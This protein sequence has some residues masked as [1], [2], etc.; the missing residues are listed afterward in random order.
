MN[1]S[2]TKHFPLCF[3]F[4]TCILRH[5]SFWLTL[6]KQLR[7]S[8]SWKYSASLSLPFSFDTG[9]FT[10]NW[11]HGGKFRAFIQIFTFFILSCHSP[12]QQF[13]V[14]FCLPLRTLVLYTLYI[15]LRWGIEY[16]KSIF[17]RIRETKKQLSFKTSET[18]RKM[19]GSGNPFTAVKN[20]LS[21]LWLDERFSR[22]KSVVRDLSMART[23]LRTNFYTMDFSWVCL[24]MYTMKRKELQ[25]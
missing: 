8:T 2:C 13:Y 9:A 1:K 21:Q 17:L 14:S 23:H 11:S 7:R 3:L 15:V 20:R 10:L 24:S 18:L 4:I 25:S 6:F 5:W 19:A 12:L 22:V 16:C